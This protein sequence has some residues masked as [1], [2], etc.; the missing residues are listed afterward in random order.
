MLLERLGIKKIEINSICTKCSNEPYFSFRKDNKT[1]R[2]AGVI[3]I[4]ND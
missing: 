4:V 2:F 1:G 3:N